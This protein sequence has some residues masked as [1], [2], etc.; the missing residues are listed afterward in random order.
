MAPP[1]ILFPSPIASDVL[2][3]KGMHVKLL[4]TFCALSPLSVLS[5]IFQERRSAQ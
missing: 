4:A 2:L 5:S 1:S 3:W